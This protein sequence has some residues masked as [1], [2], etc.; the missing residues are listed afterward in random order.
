MRK[1]VNL[2][3]SR[4][5]ALTLGALPFIAVLL[6]YLVA[7]DL[8]LEENPRDKLLPAFA[9]MGDTLLRLATEESK[10]TGEIIFWG[11]TQASLVRL[12][13][14]VGISALIALFFGLAQGSFPL[15][16]A[17]LSPFTTAI[18]M[19]PP[20]ALLPVLFIVFG[21]GEVSKVVLI[22]IGITPF[23]I[24]DLQQ[25]V[26][27][28]PEEQWIK[29]Q[30]LGANS[31][32]LITR[33]VLPQMMPRLIDAV[34]LSMGSAWLFLIAAEAI[35]ANEGLG[36]RIFLVR[37]YM[38]MDTILPY[39]AWITVLAIVADQL[40]RQLNRRAFPWYQR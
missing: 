15:A 29:A 33:M 2:K 40:L 22:V 6:L 19:V 31:W 35:A 7:S 25:R 38:S 21:L 32:Q 26:M 37:R 39:V 3:P 10:R 20:M 36:Y 23:L 17:K 34:R 30:T 28:L 27:E 1:L 13:I 9:T 4:L 11:D 12:G 8:R 5:T 14:G 24:R 18:A 16:R